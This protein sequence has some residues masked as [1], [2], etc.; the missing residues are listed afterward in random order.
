MTL[1]RRL[2][3]QSSTIFAARI[4]GAGIIFLAQA[5]IA[6]SWGAGVLGEYLLI[7]GAINLVA[8][9]MPLGFAA[10]G[11]YFAA[12]YRARGEGHLLRSFMARAYGHV[13]LAGAAVF[14]IGYFCI[15]FLGEPG[16]VLAAHWVPA[17]LMALATA[18]V[19]VNSAI[20]V[21]LKR[22]LAGFL[23]DTLFRPLV[24]IAAFAI[25]TALV[26]GGMGEGFHGMIWL[27]AAGFAAIAL[28]QF[29][30]V[31][32]A[33]RP[34]PTEGARRPEEAR[35]WWRLAI[36][37][38]IIVL[39]SDFFF[40]LDL[41]LL[42]N[43]LGR[44]ELAVFGVSARIFALVSF[45]I[46][47]VYAV[48]LPDMFE[49]EAMKDR[50]GFNRRI[51]E[52][53]LV[54]AILAVGLFGAVLLGG[55]LVLMVFGPGF[56]AGAAPLAVLC[57]A[58]VVRSLLGPAAL[59]LSIHDRPYASLPAIGLGLASLVAGNL[60]LV[61]RLGL[62]GAAVAALVAITLWSVALW[63]TALGIAGEDVSIFARLRHG[64]HDGNPRASVGVLD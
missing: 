13:V 25:A 24:V 61:P 12:E 32:R 63:L 11:T 52:A 62:M 51:G 54:A 49:S 1:R 45:G 41:L 53:N 42:S 2:L 57:L 39:A 20:L 17:G 28:V 55:P 47:A 64:S 30:F 40:D 37:W 8:V 5:G 31:V 35:R 43:L 9:V 22:P 10:V 58:L 56:A 14:A 4:V 23:G 50:E 29:G 6:R 27:M 60:M 7:V 26:G 36:P 15:S 44:E 16:R 59:V 19:F 34:I 3:S 46:S 48:T 33:T 21:G 38:A 18:T